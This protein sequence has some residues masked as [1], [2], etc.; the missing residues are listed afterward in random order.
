VFLVNGTILM[1]CVP[2][3]DGI[4]ADRTI[5]R[6]YFGMHRFEW[7]DD[8][9]VEFHLPYG[10]WIRVL[11]ANHL[12]VEDLIE[13]RPPEGAVTRYPFCTIDWARRWPSE[14]VWVARKTL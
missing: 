2:D 14:E 11:R 6:D 9:S 8:S 5:K 12:E 1:L 7:P 13:I 10:E 3:E 4:A